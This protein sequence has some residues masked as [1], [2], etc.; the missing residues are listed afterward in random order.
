MPEN[1]NKDPIF[2]R[3]ALNAFWLFLQLVVAR[4]SSFLIAVLLARRLAQAEYGQF[5]YTVSLIG[6]FL[7]LSDVGLTSFFLREASRRREDTLSIFAK[8][9]VLKMPL[10]AA[11]YLLLGVLTLATAQGDRVAVLVLSAAFFLESSARFL[12]VAF[13]ANEK[14]H[15]LVAG[16]AVHKGL[17]IAM[18]WLVS[19][20]VPGLMPVAFTY[21]AAA[22][23]LLV[24]YFVYFVRSFGIPAVGPGSGDFQAGLRGTLAA[25]A[26]M[27]L[28]G[29]IMAAYVNADIMLIKW[30]KGPEAT[31]LY[32][33]CY[34]LYLGIAAVS[35]F[36]VQA[37]V[38][39]LSAS[40]EEGDAE[41][42]GM[43]LRGAVKLLCLCS[44]PLA[45]GGT[46]LAADLLTFIYG[47]N[48]AH[49]AVVLRIF[50]CTAPINF[51]NL[52]F[53]YFLFSSRLQAENNRIYAAALLLNV[54]LNLLSI[55]RYGVAG[56]AAA[57]L[58][59]EAMFMG[60]FLF[61]HGEFLRYFRFQWGLRLAAAL[62]ALYF[63][64]TTLPEGTHLLLRVAAG[65]V[66]Y[67]VVLVLTGALEEEVK[68]IRFLFSKGPVDA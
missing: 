28:G 57:T 11:A 20:A 61:K 43:L 68:L 24:Y 53:A 52:L 62:A 13:N 55:P 44:L 48:Y 32:A 63:G 58:A 22:S 64:V 25:S 27:A 36:L 47:G 7:V 33:V 6:M 45:A 66:S 59:A 9:A 46:L 5:S 60:V 14:M 30:L 23:G 8:T 15:M 39:R 2:K 65:A 37:M 54:V 4:L 38:P 42:S 10:M 18:L 56:A 51:L 16:D 40:L 67:T 41:R 26:P 19:A 34:S 21:V 12:S 1:G 49:G 17:L 29:L 50:L 31:A 3:L 35:S